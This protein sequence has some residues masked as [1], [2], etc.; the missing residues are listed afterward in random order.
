MKTR[1]PF[2][3]GRA[4]R[5]RYFVG[6]ERE[7]E[8]VQRALATPH[9]RLLLYGAR[10]VGKSSLLVEAQARLRTE[11]Q[12][13]VVVSLGSASSVADMASRVLRAATA[14]LRKPWKGIANEV[15]SRLGPMATLR[16]DVETGRPTPTLDRGLRAA[17]VEAQRESLGAV[18]DVLDALATERGEVLGIA[19]DDFEQILKF[20]GADAEWHLRGVVGRHRSTGYVLSGGTDTLIATM[21]AQDRAFHGRF[22]LLPVPTLE[23]KTLSAWIDTGLKGAGVKSKRGVGKK[24]VQ[25]VGPRT[26]DVARLAGQAYLLAQSGGKLRVGDLPVVMDG[27][28]DDLDELLAA[29]WS[30]LT[31]RQ[32]NLLR[33]LAAGEL[34][35]FAE[36]V[37]RLYDL[38]SSAAVARTLE[39]LIQ[40]GLVVRSD[41][42]YR[43][44]NPYR[45]RWIERTALPDLGNITD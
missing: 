21:T 1:N 44:V 45:R 8:Q 10:Q 2:R 29:E 39:L 15:A 5:G 4:A 9:A 19:L 18:L 37:R 38:R 27:I 16:A 26:G 23:A 7:L 14:Q 12:A 13:S 25:M 6:R 22:E 43:L 30:L 11:G 33:A 40:K 42:G 24:I 32:Q 3:V 20:G 36:R 28:V 17:P 31:G 41:S 34:Q 35:P